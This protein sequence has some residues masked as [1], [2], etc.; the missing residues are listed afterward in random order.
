MS[1][2]IDPS[3]DP[4][5]DEPVLSVG[6][7]TA[8]GAAVLG[9]VAIYVPVPIET[10]AAFLGLVAALAPIVT[11]LWARRKVYSPATVAQLLQDRR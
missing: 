1:T 2:G 6:T 11:A 3:L 4:K 10:K 5:S 8:I 7:V 9:V